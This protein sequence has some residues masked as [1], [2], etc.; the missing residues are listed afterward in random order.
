M[1]IV[2]DARYNIGVTRV[3]KE[4]VEGDKDWKN[5]VFRVTVGYKFKL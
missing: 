2:V 1:P 5:G 3:N 4:Q